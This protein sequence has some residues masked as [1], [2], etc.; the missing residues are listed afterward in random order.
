M[1]GFISV[2][3]AMTEKGQ[4]V[5]DPEVEMIGVPE[6][7]ANGDPMLEIA[8]EAVSETVETMPKG[9]RRDPD[10][11][12]EAVRRSVRAAVAEQWGKKPLVHVHL[13]LV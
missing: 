10:A 1:L 6:T 3:L 7:T 9:R 2:A 12:A 5:S 11:V 13:L 4:I 8:L